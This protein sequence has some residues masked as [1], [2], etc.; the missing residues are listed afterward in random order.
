MRQ[1]KFKPEMCIG[2]ESCQVSS[3]VQHS[4]S[5]NLDKALLEFPRPLS[6]V[7]IKM[8]KNKHFLAKC[9]NCKKPKCIEVCEPK[10][11]VNHDGYYQINE[12]VCTYCLKC[13]EACPFNA[14]VVDE[15]RGKVIK[16]DFC[17]KREVPACVEGCIPEALV[18]VEGDEA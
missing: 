9:R 3:A 4:H 7:R 16:C 15:T 6:R 8:K 10:A 18:L 13:V 1:V 12:N 14:I 11:I 2:C 5:K 17:L